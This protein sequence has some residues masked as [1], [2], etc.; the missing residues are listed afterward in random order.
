LKKLLIIRH[1]KSDWNTSFISDFERP[2]NER[3]LRDAPLMGS[4]LKEKQ[5]IP[6]LII[7][8]GAKR[9]ISTA[10]LVSK[11]LN[12]KG[13]I[14]VNNEI[15]N[16][17]ADDIKNVINTIEEKYKTVFIFGHNPGLS[18]LVND[19][20]SQWI[21][22]KTCCVTVLDFTV[23]KWNHIIKDTAIFKEHYSPKTI[24]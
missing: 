4:F 15:Y 22:I 13:D 24:I 18:H 6:D 12:Y 2:L 14:I 5:H 21:D 23:K 11:K 17:S 8:S 1:A 10:K 16:A 20:T 3:G 9:A 7:S 19:L